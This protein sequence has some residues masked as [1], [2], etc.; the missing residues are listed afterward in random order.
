VPQLATHR[1]E[2]PRSSAVERLKSGRGKRVTE[3]PRPQ[4]ACLPSCPHCPARTAI[5]SI[6]FLTSTSIASVTVT[7]EGKMI[8]LLMALEISLYEAE[9]PWD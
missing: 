2:A 7:N 8:T 9:H 6:S 3:H 5:R 1:V 4:L